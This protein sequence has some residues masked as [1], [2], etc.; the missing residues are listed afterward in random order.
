MSDKQKKLLLLGGAH[1]L[2]PVIRE[3]HA[4]GLYVITCDYLPDNTAHKY[5]DEYHNV[6][7]LDREAVLHTAREL[8]IDGVM[9]FACDPGVVT[10]AYVAKELG[11]PSPGSFESTSILQDKGRFRAFLTDNGFT[12]PRAKRYTDKAV[13]LRDAASWTFP[14]IVKPVDC[15]GSKGVTRIDSAAQLP[16]AIERALNY[17]FSGAFIIEQFIQQ[18]GYSSDTDCFVIDGRLAYCS[19][20]EQHFDRSAENPYTPAAYAWPSSMPEAI[21]TELRAELQR[22]MT[23]LHIG[24]GVFNIE[25]RQ[26]TDGKA[27]IMECTPRGGGNR[28]S[29]VLELATGVKLIQNA[30]RAAVGL[31]VDEMSDPVYHG[32][33]A[34][35]ILHSR[36]DGLF[37][38]LRIAPEAQRFVAETDLWVVPGEAIERF[39]GANKA[40]GTLVLNF[41]DRETMDRYMSDDSWYSVVT[42]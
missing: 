17:S 1:Y 42:E 25:T 37:R 10:A 36:V 38:E 35:I 31:P 23:L 11:L 2:R 6:S 16:A 21:Q 28:L 40:I 41:P 5:S 20:D 30:V 12:V 26:G 24:T 9:S 29:E 13:A 33:W 22:L 7:I 27:Y 14:M 34:E 39:S 4:L 3:A 19:F 18:Q 8:Q 15:A 32:H